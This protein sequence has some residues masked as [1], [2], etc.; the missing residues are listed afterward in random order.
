MGEHIDSTKAQTSVPLS[1]E[2]SSLQDERI[3]RIREVSAEH[4]AALTKK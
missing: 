3:K 1:Q 4:L 2:E